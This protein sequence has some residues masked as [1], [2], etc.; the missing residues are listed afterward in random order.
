MSAAVPEDTLP[1]LFLEGPAGAG[2]TARCIERV[3][4]LVEGGTPASSILLLTPHRSY[5]RPYEQAFDRTTWQALGKATIGGLARR[6]VSLFWP[7]VQQRQKY[8][9]PT[10]TEPTFLTYEAAQYIMAR[11]VAPLVEQGFFAELKLTRHRLY[12]QLLDNLNKAAANRIPLDELGRY[13]EAARI[14]E[15]TGGGIDE[16]IR[17]LTTYRTYCAEQNLVDFSLYLEL[18]WDLMADEPGVSDHLFGT[19]LHLVYD[20]AEEDIPLAHDVVRRWL[21]DRRLESAVIAYDLDAGF[22]RFLAANP[23]SAYELG[24]ECPQRERLDEVPR[25]PA[26]L[27]EFGHVLINAIAHGPVTAPR[28]SEPGEPHF[29]AFSDRLHHQM[30]ERVAAQV[31]E[32][33]AGGSE[34]RDIAGISPFV[35]DTLYYGLS[36]RLDEAGIDYYLHRPS[37]SLRDEP[38]TR[39]LLTLANLSHPQWGLARP[40]PEAVAHMLDLCLEPAD[41]VR[42]GLLASEAYRVLDEG[43]GLE[44]FEKLPAVLRD[45]V[46]YRVGETYERLRGW[47]AAYLELEELP[48]DHF[49]SR[50]F[51]ELLSQPGFGFHRDVQAGVQVGN[52][53]ESARSFR[54]SIP[55]AVEAE[56]GAVGRGYVEM[57]QEGVISAFY[58][59][60]WAD[61]G[62]AVLI[63]PAHTFLLRGRSCAHQLWL[64]VGSTA[65]HRR[66]HQPLTN[67]YVL[68][69]DWNANEVWSASWEARFETERLT[70]MVNGLIR[71]CTGTVHLF[72]SELSAHG[73]E[74]RGELLA[75]LGQALRQLP[76]GATS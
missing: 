28:P 35:S 76:V 24:T 14:S 19:Y 1:R 13:L 4:R 71:R 48:I 37:R 41:L 23:H 32:L 26:P 38:V 5:A 62:E 73:Q 58:R 64:D 63:A 17:T 30:V 10:A 21:G 15:G 69:R 25:V 47:V 53:V 70:G 39:V 43:S 66:I 50:L 75:A 72:A 54:R 12:S 56:G 68:S 7:L 44:P 31:G 6:Y 9:F 11:L 42:A 45:R 34:A 36:N 65:W 27:R 52:L 57:V 20:N 51:G 22:R 2:K 8:P 3:R 16:V 61:P 40:H 67:P 33:A 49:L 60:G 18:L 55:H 74:Q 46:T 29:R 59:A